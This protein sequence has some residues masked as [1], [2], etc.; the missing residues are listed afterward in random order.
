MPRLRMVAKI[1]AT[2]VGV[3]LLVKIM[4]AKPPPPPP[5][6]PPAAEPTPEP[7][8]EP[9]PEPEVEP[10]VPFTEEE[11][12]KIAKKEAWVWKDFTTYVHQKLAFDATDETDHAALLDTTA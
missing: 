3:I 10:P 11:M 12:I 2:F 6:P 8:P 1:I 7:I 4:S 5:A 9:A